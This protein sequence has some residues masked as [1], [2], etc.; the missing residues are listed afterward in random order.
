M[1]S[2]K[3]QWRG[4]SGVPNGVLLVS[5]GGLGDTV[6]LAHVVRRFMGLAAD[7]EPVTMLLRA[8]AAGMAFVLP[9]Q[10]RVETVD[11]SRLRK[12]IRYRLE[13][14][15]RL[16]EANYRLVASTDYLRHPDLDEALIRACRA[17]E[18]VAMVPR[19]WPKY[20]ARLRRNAA[21]YDRLFD[22]GP[23]VRD[24]VLRWWDFADWLTGESVPP[25][26]LR[27]A[28][29]RLAP[30]ARLAAP[31]VLIQPFSAVRAKQSPVEL[32]RRVIE[33]LPEGHQVRITGAAA[34]LERNPEFKGLLAPPAVVFD[35][36]TFE[37]LVPTLKAARL[38]IT[39]DTALM[40]LAASVGAPTLALASA[41]FV[42]EIVPYAPEIAPANLHVLYRTMPCEGCLG[43]CVHPLEDG[44]YRCVAELDAA[45]VVARIGA[46][47]GAEAGP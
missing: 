17:A 21:L 36:A 47:L 5:A 26:P 11:F 39:V 35:A 41:A 29:G 34:D 22:S 37:E 14:M 23:A 32:Y 28:A 12:D 10:A 40:H 19:P 1:A 33:A 9:P 4:R 25:A 44:M 45:A 2:L 18:A 27:L 3:R 24:K 31:T 8:D 13:V 46:L 7:G 16:F 43:S 42:G 20:A 38:V 6:L 15:D 30:A